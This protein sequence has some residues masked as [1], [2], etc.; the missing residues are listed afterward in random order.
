MIGRFEVARHSLGRAKLR[1]LLALFILAAG[2]AAASLWIHAQ[3][4]QQR[5]VELMLAAQ[6]AREATTALGTVVI[7]SPGLDGP[8]GVRAQVHRGAGRA[9]IHYLDGPARDAR[10]FREGGRVWR[11]A[12]RATRPLL[13]EAGGE[14]ARLDADLLARNYVARVVGSEQIAGRP[15]MHLAL[16]RRDGGGGLHMWLDRETHFPLRTVVV[17]HA[18]RALSDT[19]YESIDYGVGPPRLPPPEGVQE[20]RF[21]VRP[22]TPEQ[23]AQEAGFQPLQPAYLPPGFELVGWHLHRFRGGRGPAIGLRY[24]DGLAGLSVIQMKA[25]ERRGGAARPR[26]AGSEPEREAQRHRRGT[27]AAAD[28]PHVPRR[29]GAPPGTGEG[30]VAREYGDI[31]VIVIGELPQDELQRVA[32]NMR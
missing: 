23:A 4:A 22:T 16:R 26:G 1:V 31:T 10:V 30:K 7:R 32:D 14:V 24:T 15:A 2:A 13:L 28:T 12:G 5:A 9:A 19:A 18:G 8:Q 25:P 29:R 3:G 21:S 20:P 27:G 6:E 11:G 17:N